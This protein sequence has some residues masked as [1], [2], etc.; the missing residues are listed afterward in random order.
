MLKD[1]ENPSSKQ[2]LSVC[3]ERKTE[4]V[5]FLVLVFFHVFTVGRALLA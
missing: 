4:I 3:N 5:L 1:L 2:L